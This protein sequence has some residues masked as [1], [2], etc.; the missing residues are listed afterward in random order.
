M[1]ETEWEKDET[2]YLIF[3][4]NKC[5]RY[6]YVKTIQKSKKC[7]QCGHIHKVSNISKSGEIVNGMTNAI[8]TVKE[9]QNELA[10]KE[11]GNGPE[12]RGSQDFK[13]VRKQKG[14]RFQTNDMGGESELTDKF[15]RMLIEISGMY[16]EFPDYIIE[17]M[18]KNYGIPNSELK[19]LIK[20]FLKKGFLIR[21]ENYLYT[22]NN[23]IS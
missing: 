1:E 2:P 3:R 22:I 10:Q 12:F 23:K 17:M 18:A 5:K 21:L 20:Y 11:M 15:K 7:L 14:K 9:K 19:L 8:N 13:I 4:C 6:L 16:K